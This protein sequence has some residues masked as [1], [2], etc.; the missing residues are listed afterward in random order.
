MALNYAGAFDSAPA[1]NGSNGNG[2]GRKPPSGL[3]GFDD[4]EPAPEWAP[5]PAGMYT[6]RVVSGTVSRTKKGDDCYRMVFEVTDGEQRGR[7]VSR[8]WVFSERA[9]TYAKRDLAAFGLTTTKQLLEP[10]PPTGREVYVRL[11]VALQRGDNGSEFN[12]VKRI[13]VLRTE[14]SPA[15]PF[16][17]DP[18]AE[19]SE[20]G[21]Q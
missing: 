10:F 9:V 8:T 1:G 19:T 12:D 14:D 5:L 2:G 16:L 11:A 17:I 13:D 18:D 6:A 20:G 4:A 15:K 3:D 21:K 7:R